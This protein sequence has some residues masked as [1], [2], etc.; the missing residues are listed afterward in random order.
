MVS[1]TEK[2]KEIETAKTAIIQS[3]NPATGELLGECPIMGKFQVDQAVEQAWKA[4]DEWQLLNYGQ[5]ARYLLK[6]RRVISQNADAITELISQEVGKPRSEAYAAELNGPLDT[7]VWLTENADRLL[8]DQMV[9]LSNPLLSTKQNVISFEPLGVIGVIAPWNYPFSIPMM[10]IAMALMVGNTVVLKPSEK[11]SLIG[12]KIGEL[13]NEAGFPPGVVSVITGDRSTG[14]LLCETR[15]SKL[16]FTGSVEGGRKV[17]EQASANLIPVSLELGGKDA[18]IVLPDAPIEWTAKALVWG[19]FTNAGQACASI[20]RVYILKGKRTD[21]LIA[22]IVEEAKKLK[23]GPYTDPQSDIGPVIDETQLEK[24]THH[25]KQAVHSGAIVQTGGKRVE[26]LPGYFFEPTV[27]TGVDHSMIVMKEE[28]FGPVLSIMV[29]D[30]EDQ[31]VELVNDSEFGLCASVW[32]KNLRRAENIARDLNVGTVTINDCLF[33]HAAPQLPWGGLKK[34]G[35]GRSHSQFGLM[36]LVNIKHI[37][38]DAAGGSLR[39]WWYPYGTNKMKTL[40]GGIQLFHGPL[41]KKISGFFEFVLN[42]LKNP[43]GG[44]S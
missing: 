7:C 19:A 10:T 16:V 27:L 25:V 29:V 18:A 40:R 2:E 12:I 22:A 30:T 37:N 17:M 11:S 36:D 13:I 26:S 6:L 8:K 35:F 15:L 9:Q 23:V 21:K 43:K 33:T 20:E 31:V 28:T 34:S 4:F 44:P 3:I 32:G 5:R 1:S 39:L 42:N 38:I 24:I 41:W 14:K